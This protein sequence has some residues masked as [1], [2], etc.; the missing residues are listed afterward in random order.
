MY[1]PH[2]S[3]SLTHTYTLTHSLTH[4]H[5]HTHT[6]S[7]AVREGQ[8]LRGRQLDIAK[9]QQK[10]T[11]RAKQAKMSTKE[12]HM[13]LY[14]T[15]GAT[16]VAGKREPSVT[17]EKH[18]PGRLAVPRTNTNTSSSSS[19]SSSFAQMTS[20]QRARASNKPKSIDGKDDACVRVYEKVGETC[21][22]CIF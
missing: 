14:K 17:Y 1:A 8:Q 15:S 16:R 3:L 9:Q 21:L 6:H 20:A 7:A 5:Q 12:R 11:L 18:R 13:Q 2:L 19:N 4:S 10:H 22:L